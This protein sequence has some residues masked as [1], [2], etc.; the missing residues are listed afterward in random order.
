MAL[1]STS[2]AWRTITVPLLDGVIYPSTT[3]VLPAVAALVAFD[4]AG[5]SYA[6]RPEWTVSLV[7]VSE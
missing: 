1:L 2:E 5:R 3:A 6:V 7:V 4:A